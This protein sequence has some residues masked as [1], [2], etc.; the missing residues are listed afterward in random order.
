MLFVASMAVVSSGSV[1]AQRH[2]CMAALASCCYEVVHR[3]YSAN[4]R[5]QSLNCCECV[6]AVLLLTLVWGVVSNPVFRWMQLSALWVGLA[7]AFAGRGCV[8]QACNCTRCV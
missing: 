4:H 3:S 2:T 1:Y 8:E 7:A 6:S 5:G